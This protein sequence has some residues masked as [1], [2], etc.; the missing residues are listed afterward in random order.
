MIRLVSMACPSKLSQEEWRL[1]RRCIYCFEINPENR[2][3]S[4]AHGNFNDKCI[5]CGRTFKGVGVPPEGCIAVSSG[6]RV[7][8]RHRGSR[9]VG[10]WLFKRKIKRVWKVFLNGG[11]IEVD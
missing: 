1:F 3:R 7:R 4:T 11:E 5:L 10:W 6:L 8:T 9:S 2:I